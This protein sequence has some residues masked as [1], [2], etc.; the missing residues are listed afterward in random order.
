MRKKSMNIYISADTI[1]RLRQYAADHHTT[2]SQAVTDWIWKQKVS[3]SDSRDKV[4]EKRAR[5]RIVAA[6]PA[7]LSD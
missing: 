1:E 2:V 7:S 6:G 4:E 3:G 5:R